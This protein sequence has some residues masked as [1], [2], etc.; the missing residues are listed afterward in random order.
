MTVNGILGKKIGM[1]QL[2]REDG[3]PVGVT[4]IQ[5]GPCVITQVRTL[6]KDGYLAVQLGF[7][8][9]GRFPEGQ[10]FKRVKRA[11]LRPLNKPRAGHLRRVGKLFRHLREVRVSELG[12]LQEGQTVDV[13]LF[14]PGDL[15]DVTGTSKGHGFSGVVKRHGFKGGPKTHG[16]SDRHRAP[17]SVGA[18]TFAGRVLKGLRMAG[19]WGH[20]R[21]TVQNLEVVQVDKER[22]LLFLQG[23]VPGP[24]NGLLR[25]SRAVKARS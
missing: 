22:N 7:E 3:S 8:E 24:E 18:T 10:E 2:F 6:G 12:D 15:V 9:V 13:G 21:I 20:E 5:A 16:Q 23:P 14:K 19:H 25:I 1:T 17:G 11:D 4:A